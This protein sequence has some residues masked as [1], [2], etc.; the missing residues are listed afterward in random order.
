MLLNSYIQG[1]LRRGVIQGDL[2]EALN[3]IEKSIGTGLAALFWF[4]VIMIIV[5]ILVIRR[6]KY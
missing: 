1:D 2:R 3:V 5:G 6:E 4:S